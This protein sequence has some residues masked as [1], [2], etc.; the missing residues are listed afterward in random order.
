MYIYIYIYMYTHT[1]IHTNIIL[2]YIYIYIYIY[3][4][5][6]LLYIRL[7]KWT[8]A[9]PCGRPQR[10]T[11]HWESR[12]C[13]RMLTVLYHKIQNCLTSIQYHNA[14]FIMSI[15]YHT[16]SRSAATPRQDEEDEPRCRISHIYIYIYIYIYNIIIY[17]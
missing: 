16:K 4:H 13:G 6:S 12:Y 5:I 15:L 11:C 1:Y 14:E 17:I 2:L 8:C 9:E 10:D 7:R 3:T